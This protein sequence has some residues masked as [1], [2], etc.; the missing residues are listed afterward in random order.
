M[1]PSSQVSALSG[2]PRGASVLP[3]PLLVTPAPRGLGLEGGAGV[4]YF[5]GGAGAD[6][7]VFGATGTPDWDVV[8]DFNAAE[9]T[10]RLGGAVFSGF[11][12]ADLD[13]DGAAD[14]TLLGYAG[15]NVAMLNV[16]NLTLPEWN[17]LIVG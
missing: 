14:D 7:F 11:V 16:S 1:G 9:D 13:G 4:D 8:T 15:G 17:G 6:E 5:T 3:L 12:L 2:M 10:I